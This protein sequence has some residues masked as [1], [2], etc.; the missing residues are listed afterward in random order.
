MIQICDFSLNSFAPVNEN[1]GAE[2]DVRDFSR[3]SWALKA[4]I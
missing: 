3:E 4:D 1:E 2:G